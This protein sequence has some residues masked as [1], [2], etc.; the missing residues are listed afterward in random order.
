MI[1]SES[2]RQNRLRNVY[3]QELLWVKSFHEAG[4]VPCLFRI[5]EFPSTAE[6]FVDAN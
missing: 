6:R 1:W 5:R 3:N 2:T 4:L